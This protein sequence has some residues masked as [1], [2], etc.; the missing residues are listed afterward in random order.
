MHLK[1]LVP[2]VARQ[3]RTVLLSLHQPSPD[4][5]SLLDSVLLLAAGRRVYCGAAAG[6]CESFGSAYGL[7]CPPGRPVAEHLL[8]VRLETHTPADK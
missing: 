1:S 3:G 6:A 4:M 7:P 5:Y 2:Q 8:Q